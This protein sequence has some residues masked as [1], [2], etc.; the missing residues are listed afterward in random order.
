V[1]NLDLVSM[2]VKGRLILKMYLK[3]LENDRV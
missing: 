1:K 2:N 3:G